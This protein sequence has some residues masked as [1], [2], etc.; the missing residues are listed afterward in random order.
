MK[1]KWDF[2]SDSQLARG[3]IWRLQNLFINKL[4]PCPSFKWHWEHNGLRNFQSSH[5][6]SRGTYGQWVLKMCLWNIFSWAFEFQLVDC[7][8][9]QNKHSSLKTTKRRRDWVLPWAKEE[10]MC[11]SSCK[12][13]PEQKS[14]LPQTFSEKNS[15]FD[16][17]ENMFTPACI[18]SL[19]HTPHP[20]RLLPTGLCKDIEGETSRRMAAVEQSTSR[21]SYL[22]KSFPVQSAGACYGWTGSLQNPHFKALPWECDCICTLGD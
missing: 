3:Y 7:T 17:R 18:S 21:K 8:W 11:C 1:Y 10:V 22:W 20:P 2:F 9:G 14:Q 15:G 5:R 13:T 4:H 12:H 6:S 19:F 16:Q